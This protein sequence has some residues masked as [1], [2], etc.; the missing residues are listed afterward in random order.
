[1]KRSIDEA[2]FSQAVVA[3]SSQAAQERARKSN[4]REYELIEALQQQF[5]TALALKIEERVDKGDDLAEEE[6]DSIGNDAP[7][8]RL[9]ALRGVIKDI[10]F[11][12][13]SHGIEEDEISDKLADA[14]SKE[15]Q[16]RV[17]IINFLKICV[18]SKESFHAILHQ[19]S[20]F[21]MSNGVL[22]ATGYSKF[23]LKIT[24][25]LVPS[26]LN[27]LNVDAPFLFAIFY[28]GTKQQKTRATTQNALKCIGKVENM[29]IDDGLLKSSKI[30]RSGIGSSLVTMTETA[31]FDMEKF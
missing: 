23:T 17:L 24:L 10:P 20:F 11:K 6:T 14:E 31:S 1:M 5:E 4:E 3:E 28:T 18:P 27:A 13:F 22:H 2:Q 12:N 7:G 25:Y 19:L 21:L 15:L 8:L 16:T 30:T 26:I 29:K 9:M